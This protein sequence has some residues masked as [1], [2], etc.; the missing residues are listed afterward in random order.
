MKRQV[1][2]ALPWILL[3][4]CAGSSAVSA[5]TMVTAVHK[6]GTSFRVRMID[7][8]KPVS[9]VAFRLSSTDKS[10]AKHIVPVTATTGLDG[11]A[12]FDRVGAGDATLKYASAVD[13]SDESIERTVVRT[14][15]RNSEVVA[16][17]FDR[18]P[19]EVRSANGMIRDPNYYPKLSQER[20]TV[21]LVAPKTAQVRDTAEADDQGR[22]S[23]SKAIPAG[24]YDLQ[25]A[26]PFGQE[27][28]QILIEVRPGTQF[29]ELN[30]SFTAS[31][32]GLASSQHQEHPTIRASRVCGVANDPEGASIEDAGV[33]LLDGTGTKLIRTTRSDPRGRF[34][35]GPEDL[36][37][38]QLVVSRLGFAPF[39]RNLRVT[40]VGMRPC[41]APIEV[42]LG[43]GDEETR[44][45]TR[46]KLP[47]SYFSCQRLNRREALVPPKP[48]E[49]LRA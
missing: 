23:F 30:G 43:L 42:Q 39:V 16:T 45:D 31:N 10:R 21:M 47:C 22:Y 33:L 7:R 44:N 2:R 13:G 34:D 37:D 49:L 29:Q 32:C 6:V 14:G 19:I 20:L 12:S 17:L 36:G 26:N 9:G 5:C 25:L 27:W 3:L 15:K 48:K 11:Y 8:G 24:I 38:Y 18:N 41:T 28:G 35:L 1:L 40:S 4:A 46:S